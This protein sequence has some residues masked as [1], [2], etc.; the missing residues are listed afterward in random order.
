MFR[1][2]NSVVFAFIL[3]FILVLVF[4]S[5]LVFILVFIF[6]FI[7]FT[8]PSGIV[9]PTCVSENQI[10]RGR[11]CCQTRGVNNTVMLFEEHIGWPGEKSDGDTHPIPK[12]AFTS[13]FQR[14]R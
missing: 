12:I 3:V 2:V 7:V 8:I 9:P 6:I 1:A 13:T 14:Q 11:W 10:G 4:I 5:I